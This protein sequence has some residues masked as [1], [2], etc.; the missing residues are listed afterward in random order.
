VNLPGHI[1]GDGCTFYGFYAFRYAH[2]RF[3]YANPELQNQMGHACAVTTDHY[4][5]WGQR[6]M[7]EYDAYMPAALEGGQAAANQRENSG[8]DSEKPVLRVV[9]A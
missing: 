9:S 6:Q 8:D 1:C 4:R 3:N 7:A 2:A 5:R